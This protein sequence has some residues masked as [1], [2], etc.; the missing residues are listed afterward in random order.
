VSAGDSYHRAIEA[1]FDTVHGG[2]VHERRVRV[3]SRHLAE[4]MPDGARVLDV[5]C[6]DGRIASIVPTHRPD[7]EVSG[8]DIFVRDDAQIP[9]R[10]F[11][12][13]SIPFGDGEVD[14]VMLVDVLHHAEEP[15]TLLREATRV[16]GRAVVLKDVTPLGPLSDATLR[17]MDWVGNARHGVPLPYTFWTQE[18]WRRAFHD[19]G[20]SV[21]AKRRRLG[22][23]P[24]PAN[25]A[26]EK[27][28][29]FI[30]RLVPPHSRRS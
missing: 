17:F 29:H 22:L 8:I 23:Y 13:L 7:V 18:Q 16:A 5:G 27:R 3:L 30:V 1:V 28:M 15:M 19:L 11:D 4:L 20:L 25:L 2:L 26:F 24:W 6:G 14:V 9:V 10:E 21:A 12:G